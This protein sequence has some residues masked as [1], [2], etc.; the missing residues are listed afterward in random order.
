VGCSRVPNAS[1]GA[2]ARARFLATHA[3]PAMAVR[4]VGTVEVDFPDRD[5][6]FE[7]RWGASGDSL[8][9]IG[10]S[11]PVRVLDATMLRDSILVAIRPKD[12]GVAGVLRPSDGFGVEGLRFLLRPWEFDTPWM[13]E[14]L[15]RAEAEPAGDGWRFRGTASTGAGDVRFTLDLTSRG[16]PSRLELVRAGDAAGAASVR[17]GKPRGFAAGAYPRWIEWSRH[18]ARVR[19]DLRDVDRLP[20]E[21]L[22]LLPGPPAECRVVSLTDPE[23]QDFIQRILG[24]AGEPGSRS[25]GTPR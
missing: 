13:R 6:S 5:G 15:E 23:G 2:E 16:A 9:V 7:A 17:Y 21:G 3:A 20:A 19:L 8:V 24:S 18:D 12:F 1:S 4:G 14:A 11:G 22:R 10:Y 25:P